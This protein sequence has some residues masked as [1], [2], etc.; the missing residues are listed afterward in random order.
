MKFIVLFLLYGSSLAYGQLKE[1]GFYIPIEKKN[2]GGETYE[3]SKKSF[4]ITEKPLFR[5]DVID[6][7]TG[8]MNAKKTVFFDLLLKSEASKKVKK[9]VTELNQYEI[10]IVLDSQVI[11]L[12]VF[13]DSSNYSKIRFYSS[14]LKGKIQDIH[15]YLGEVLNK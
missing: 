7:R 8:I 15:D 13:E 4:C 9:V 10:A 2:C 3:L 6:G 11:G 12:A 14:G 5:L 1:D